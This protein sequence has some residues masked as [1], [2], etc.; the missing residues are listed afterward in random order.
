MLIRLVMSDPTELASGETLLH[1]CNLIQTEYF[2]SNHYFGG[3]DFTFAPRTSQ[4]QAAQRI[5][6]KTHPAFA[7]CRRSSLPSWPVGTF[8]DGVHDPFDAPLDLLK[9]AATRF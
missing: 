3:P 5:T 6:R 2:C 7:L 8:L 4:L 9:G 1:Y